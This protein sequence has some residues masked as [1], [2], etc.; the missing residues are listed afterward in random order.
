MSSSSSSWT[1]AHLGAEDITVLD[2]A[3]KA[4]MAGFRQLSRLVPIELRQSV[5]IAGQRWEG[6]GYGVFTFSRLISDLCGRGVLASIF[7]A[8]RNVI[9][10]ALALYWQVQD[11]PIIIEG[12][13]KDAAFAICASLTKEDDEKLKEVPKDNEETQVAMPWALSTLPLPETYKRIVGNLKH[14][15]EDADRARLLRDVLFFEGLLRDAPINNHRRDS[16]RENAAQHHTTRE[17]QQD[18]AQH[19]TAH[20]SPNNTTQQAAPQDRKAQNKATQRANTSRHRATEGGP[21]STKPGMGGQTTER[22]ARRQKENRGRQ[23]A[24]R[25]HPRNTHRGEGGESRR[26]Q[27]TAKRRRATTRHREEREAGKQKT[28]GG[29]SRRQARRH[30]AA[31]GGR[32][33]ASGGWGGVGGGAQQQ[34]APHSKAGKGAA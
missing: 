29:N 33:T 9:L 6:R 2:A 16:A 20:R 25:G 7:D 34:A 19:D 26:R 24:G 31:K 10:V 12:E 14:S 8:C 30:H 32:K 27:Q 21:R 5:V 28:R 18:T 23:A 22:R 13:A 4:F 17:A 3:W 15:L 1:W 11:M